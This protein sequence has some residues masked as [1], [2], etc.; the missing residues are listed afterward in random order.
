MGPA[1]RGGNGDAGEKGENGMNGA[2]YLVKK[3]IAESGKKIR[4][5]KNKLAEWGKI[6]SS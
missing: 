2:K 1:E 4:S 3:D 6:D 5:P